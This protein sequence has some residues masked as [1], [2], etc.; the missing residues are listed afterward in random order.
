MSACITPSASSRRSPG[1]VV[2]RRARVRLAGPRAYCVKGPPSSTGRHRPERDGWSAA[3]ESCEKSSEARSSR[4]LRTAPTTEYDPRRSMSPPGRLTVVVLGT[5]AILFTPGGASSFAEGAAARQ[6]AAAV[7]EQPVQSFALNAFKRELDGQWPG[8]RLASDGNVYFASASHSAHHGAS[9]FKYDTATGQVIEL[10]HE[11]TDVCGE[12]VQT[13]RRARSTA[14]SSRPTVGCT[15]RPISRRISR[16]LRDLDRPARPG[17]R[18]RHRRHPRLRGHPP[19]L[20]G[21]L[22]D[23]RR[24]D[25]KLSLRLHHRPDR[26]AGR[27]RLPH[28]HRDRREGRAR[29]GQRPEQRWMGLTSPTGRSSTSAETSGSRSK[30][31]VATCC[32]FTAIPAPSRFT[33]M[34]C[35]RSSDGTPISRRPIRPCRR[36]ARLPGCSRSTATGP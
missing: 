9:F 21:L 23:R 14:T 16:R 17:L 18:D 32:R 6:E 35:R 11:I 19:G 22:R 36:A 13:I 29:T 3:R 8:I 15:W 20:H 4:W 28:R 33:P 12:D 2:L 27:L 24:P 7:G 5:A 26:G 30:T 34:R 1:P 25:S 10:V 31:R